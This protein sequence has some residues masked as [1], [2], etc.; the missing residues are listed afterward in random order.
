[1]EYQEIVY[2]IDD[3]VATITLNRPE[4]LNAVTLRTTLEL[5]HASFV[6]KRPPKFRRIGQE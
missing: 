5:R 1:V 4:K 6:E 3:P 2:D